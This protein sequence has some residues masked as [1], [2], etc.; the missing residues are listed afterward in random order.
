M[1]SHGWRSAEREVLGT[2]PPAPHKPGHAMDGTAPT[3]A[4]TQGIDVT[5]GIVTPGMSGDSGGGGVGV[6]EVRGAVALAD[7]ARAV[8]PPGDGGGEASADTAS[9]T[10][11]RSAE[12][13]GRRCFVLALQLWGGRAGEGQHH[14]RDLEGAGAQPVHFCL[15]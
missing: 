7:V 13:A 6:G 5:G 9:P 4:G 14:R 1:E 11:A 3:P 12:H 10:G 2:P 15:P 8:L